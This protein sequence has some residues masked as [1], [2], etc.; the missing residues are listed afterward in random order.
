MFFFA[1]AW[2]DQLVFRFW[3]LLLVDDWSGG[4]CLLSP[5]MSCPFMEFL[6]FSIA[7][8]HAAHS[9][10]MCSTEIL[11][12][13][14]GFIFKS[15][16]GL[17]FCPA[18]KC[19]LCLYIHTSG[20]NIKLKLWGGMAHGGEGLWTAWV[21]TSGCELSFF[22]WWLLMTGIWI[23]TCLVCFHFFAL[24]LAKTFSLNILYPFPH[25]LHIDYCFF[26]QFSR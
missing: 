18:P 19:T 22:Y 20:C 9:S 24:A 12:H 25:R 8:P 11:L 1:R 5:N 16:D 13:T 17:F 23:G 2:V 15:E 21:A 4:R 26:V 7:T 3:R 14:W 10:C 6:C